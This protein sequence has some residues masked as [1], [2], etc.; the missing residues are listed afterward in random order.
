MLNRLT[1]GTRL[2]IGF[3]L[4]VLILVGASVSAIAG[5]LSLRRA[6]AEVRNQTAQIVLAKTTNSQ[7][8]EVMVYMGAVAA[9][10]DPG[11]VRAYTAEIQGARARYKANLETLKAMTSTPESLKAV[12][13][14]EGAVGRARQANAE[15]LALA[16]A[17]RTGEA[18]KAFATRSCGFLPQWD[19]V[20]EALNARRQA[21]MDQ[22][23]AETEAQVGR[24][25]LLMVAGGIVAV[26]AAAGLGFV[27]SRSITAP[28][29]GFM[30]VLSALAKGDL[31]VRAQV[32][33]RD[34]IGQLGASL[35]T[36]L[37]RLSAT[38][39]EVAGA[40]ATVASGA[41]ELSASADQMAGT[42]REIARRGEGLNAATGAVMA[43]LGQFLASLE[44]VA[45]HVRASVGQAELAVAS[46]GEGAQ[47]SLDA[48]ARMGGIHDATVKIAR[49]VAVIQELAQQTN[50]LSLNAAIEAAKA[51]DK[52]RG[53]SVVADEVRKLADRSREATVEI[54]AVIG[55][56]Q[57]AVEGGAAS[58]R[59]TS[60][61]MERIRD[62]ITGVSGRMH[63][64]GATTREHSA[65][66]GDLTRRMEDSAR[67]VGLNA[68]A[69]RQL[70]ASVEEITRTASA[71]A[72]VSETM[73]GA[74]AQFEV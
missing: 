11:T 27:I 23:M 53:F 16:E 43:V 64:I 28:V 3:G 72:Q 29:A 50:L 52:G 20:F 54:N 45:E 21:R 59:A 61:L 71:L 49:S 5:F 22:A 18:V 30:G 58:V 26:L 41:M 37:A 48:A 34:E 38:L 56:A 62:A 14:V 19:A 35:N 33:S 36:A 31:T 4:M 63:E 40:S 70:A 51:G 42:T 55:H 8:L 24:G 32:D 1:I 47:G 9:S 65:T 74:I 2:S 7:A 10:T 60:G 39:K 15:V 25:I 69:T 17:G 46:T 73:A 44:Q 68:T 6:V 12:Q 66:A 57:E 13:E 67:E